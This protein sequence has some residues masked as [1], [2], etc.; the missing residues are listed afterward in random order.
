[1]WYQVLVHV[2]GLRITSLVTT[3]LRGVNFYEIYMYMYIYT[4]EAL[5]TY[6]YVH[7]CV[8]VRIYAVYKGIIMDQ[9]C[10]AV[11]VLLDCTCAGKTLCAF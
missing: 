2:C 8:H 6:M 11:D 4:I 10:H 9:D 3:C 7:V 5:A 1:M